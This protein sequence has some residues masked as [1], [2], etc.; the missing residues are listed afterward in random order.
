MS[1]LRW[2]GVFAVLAALP[3][4]LGNYHNDV[5][6][7]L[8]L[9]ITLA[10]GYNFLF[11]I[12][13]Q[14]AFSHFAF[15]GIGAY[16]VVIFLFQLQL[17]LPLAVLLGIVV[18]VVIALAVAIP[19]TRLEGFYLALV[20][21]ALAQLFIVVLNEGGALTGGT[22]GLTNYR[23]PDVFGVRITGPG[24]TVVIV[25]LMLS[26]LAVL[27]RLDRSWFGRACRAVRDNP[28]A[29]AAMGV[30]VARTKVIVFTLTSAL[31]GLAGMVYAFVDN[32]VNPPIFGLDNAFL[33]L[34]MV[35]VGGAGRHAGAVVGA[36][37]LY[38]LPF[39]LSPLVGHHHALVFGVLVV[40]A[41]LLQPRGLIGIY[42]AFRHSRG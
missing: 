29:A 4:F 1:T 32:T 21:L 37:L 2:L 20:T 13:G 25:F 7:K 5:Y 8:L 35:I 33:I 41:I 17:P 28:E 22:G 26:T 38:L 24:Y 39:W 10:L 31:A 42:D 3:F 14:V 11:G 15:Y 30:N 23:L 6:R 12:C 18:C 36:I 40:A 27:L 16:S 9:W 34:F 19:S